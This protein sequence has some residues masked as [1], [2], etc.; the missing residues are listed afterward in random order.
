MTFQCS[1]VL[2]VDDDMYPVSQDM[3]HAAI[4]I[5]LSLLSSLSTVGKR[6]TIA[7]YSMPQLLEK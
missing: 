5:S 4:L 1:R 3:V 7:K 2:D 6:I